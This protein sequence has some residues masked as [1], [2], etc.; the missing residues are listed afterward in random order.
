MWN[1]RWIEGNAT[2]TML[3]SSC[4]TNCAAHRSAS[5]SP[6]ADPDSVATAAGRSVPAGTRDVLAREMSFI[7]MLL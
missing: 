3:K 7:A 5:V 4:S 6:G 1:S 2:L